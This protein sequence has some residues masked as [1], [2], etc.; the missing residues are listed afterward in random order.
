MAQVGR[1]V[2]QGRRTWVGI[3]VAGCSLALQCGSAPVAP[4]PKTPVIATDLRHSET[5][6]AGKGGLLLRVQTWL[7]ATSPARA[8]L[9]VVHGL[10]DHGDRYAGLASDLA[11]GGWAVHA[12]DLRGHGKSP[13]EKVWVESFDDY[14]QDVAQ[15]V[16][17]ARQMTPD[18]PLFVF[19]HSM[20]GAIA[21]LYTLD[22][23]PAPDGLVL[24]APALIPGNDVT[25][26][27]IWVT[28]R[29]NSIAPHS[30]VL[31]LPDAKFSRDPKVVADIACDPLVSHE[32]GPAHTAAELLNALERIEGR[33]AEL[34]VPLLDLHGTEDQLTNPDGSKRLVE[35]AKTRDKTLR[36]YPNVQHDLLH[37][38]EGQKIQSE[39][40]DW[41]QARLPAASTAT[42]S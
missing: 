27:L 38:P 37:E 6:V 1:A 20:G 18:R 35:R 24:S 2:K 25:G 23:K 9:V 8:T 39:I 13:G 11:Q 41:L 22:A 31:D 40:V 12:L 34:N 33:M 3:A 28:R 26:F 4:C 19:G 30:K 5:T 14:A 21:T 10:K 16:A 32:P 29:L 36:L 17:F 7:P 15:V 42:A